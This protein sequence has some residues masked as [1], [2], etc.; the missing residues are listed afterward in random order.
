MAMRE[1]QSDRQILLGRRRLIIALGAAA[2]NIG[3]AYAAAA[4]TTAEYASA[5]LDRYVGVVN[6]H[7]ASRFAEVCTDDY[8]QHSGRSG[9]GLAAQ[10]ENFRTIF[11]R[12]PDIT[13]QVEDR[14]IGGDKIV[15]RNTFSATHT[16]TVLGVAPTGRRISF[17]TID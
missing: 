5:I 15:A 4:A 1:I 3:G 17:R 12:W 10:V 14:I 6:A 16:R 8:I 7:E 2:S 11:K 9:S 13:M